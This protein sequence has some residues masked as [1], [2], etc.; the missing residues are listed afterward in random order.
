MVNPEQM[1]PEDL[2]G[3]PFT[4]DYEPL[5]LQAGYMTGGQRRPRF[6]SRWI[7]RML[8][9]QRI[10]FALRMIKGPILSGARFY[11][12]DPNSSGDE[13]SPVKKYLIKNISRFW[14]HSAAKALRAIEWGFSGNEC[15]Y[16]MEDDLICF[17]SLK[18]IHPKDAKILT[19]DGNKIGMSVGNV[20]GRRGRIYLGGPKGLWQ[21]HNREEKPWYGLS[22]LFGAFQPW[23]EFHEDGGAKDIRRLYYHKYAFSGDVGYFPTGREP[24]TQ[25]APGSQPRSNREVMRSMLAKRKT[26]ASIMF[27][28]TRYEDGGRKWEIETPSPGP[29]AAP[30]LE[31]HSDLKEE[32]F[33]GMGVPNEVAQATETGSGYSGRKVPQEAFMSMLQEI[34]NWLC[35]DFDQQ[36]LRPMVQFNFGAKDYPYEIIP[37]GLLRS[38]GEDEEKEKDPYYGHGGGEEGQQPQPQQPQPQFSMVM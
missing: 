38:T 9:D 19:L 26:G 31:Y 27:P 4:A 10:Q 24:D 35:Y 18:I 30:V 17:D 23:L 22:R 11:V 8:P 36:V 14:A 25:S 5:A 1:K 16:R 2:L 21:V 13:H 20:K 32:I 34:V 28:G 7:N 15:L 29:G 37:F 3:K 6:S 33:E 12:K